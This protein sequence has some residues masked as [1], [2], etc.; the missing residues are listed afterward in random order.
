[1]H[2]TLPYRLCITSHPHQ[3]YSCVIILCIPLSLIGC[4]SPPILTTFLCHHL[5]IS[6]PM[7]IQ[8]TK[9]WDHY[10]IHLL[11]QWLHLI[12]QMHLSHTSATPH[13]PNIHIPS[14]ISSC[15]VCNFTILPGL[16]PHCSYYNT[17]IS[18]M[19][20]WYVL[21]LNESLVREDTSEQKSSEG[22]IY[23]LS[24]V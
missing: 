15:S 9:S 16:Y 4:V 20:V 6:F 17:L 24:P 21:G 1:M 5:T 2:T 8:P 13:P 7:A 19:N 10:L 22:E 23:A 14:S 18:C 11:T 3:H 12:G